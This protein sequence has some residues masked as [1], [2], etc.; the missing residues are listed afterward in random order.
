MNHKLSLE[1]IEKAIQESDPTQQRRLLHDLPRL[2]KI[3]NLDYSLLKLAEPS[4]DFWN[5]PDDQ[6]YDTL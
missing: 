3:P 4:F 6:I 1:Q 5:N 2:L